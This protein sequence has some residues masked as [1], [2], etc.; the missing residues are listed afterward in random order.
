M[1]NVTAKIK[2]PGCGLQTPVGFKE[3]KWKKPAIFVFECSGCA[4]DVMAKV[5][6]PLIKKSQVI[7]SKSGTTQFG[8][9]VGVKIVKPSAALLA[10]LKQEAEERAQEIL[11]SRNS[12]GSGDVAGGSGEASDSVGAQDG[13]GEPNASS[14][15][16][17][18]PQP[19][20]QA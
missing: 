17:I 19:N 3:P 7:D 6:A 5:E 18:D 15:S 9:K 14:S 2:C 1:K 12:L 20:A 13:S 10:M 4:S 16:H 8:C 11:Q